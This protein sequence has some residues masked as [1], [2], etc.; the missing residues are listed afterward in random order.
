MSFFVVKKEKM[1]LSAVMVFTLMILG[2]YVLGNL[3]QPVELMPTE[4]TLQDEQKQ[5]PKDAEQDNEGMQGGQVILYDSTADN[6]VDLRLT[7]DYERSQELD[8]LRL[9]MAN[10][11]VTAEEIAKAKSTYDNIL[12]TANIE[13][14]LEEKIMALGFGDC[15]YME[16]GERA[17]VVVQ[18]EQ[19]T[20]EQYLQ[21]VDIVGEST[22]IAH[23]NIEV[24]YYN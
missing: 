19:V 16:T 20:A 22:G 2:Y 7:R 10:G 11:S 4:A 23:K 21:I 6:F 18:A 8:E 9:T 5:K 12:A 24:R 17:Q 15:V 1:L 3:E 13:D 14:D